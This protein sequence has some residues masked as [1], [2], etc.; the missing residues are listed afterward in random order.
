MDITIQYLILRYLV[1]QS[2]FHR[3]NIHFSNYKNN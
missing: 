1:I 2:D 3:L